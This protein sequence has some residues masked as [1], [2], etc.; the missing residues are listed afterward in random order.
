MKHYTQALQYALSLPFRSW[1]FALIMIVFVLGAFGCSSKTI[2]DDSEVPVG[3]T[4]FSFDQGTYPSDLDL[5]AKYLINPGDVLDVLFQ[6]KR[7]KAEKFPITLYHTVSLRFVNVPELNVTQEVMPTGKIVLPY[8][9]EISVLG[10]TASELTKE[11]KEAYSSVLR[12]PEL[13]VTIPNFNVRIDQIREDLR[14]APR[15]LSK[16]IY[17]RPDGVATFPLIGRQMVA[18]KTIE[19]VNSIIQE[20][21]TDF[22]PG[23]KVDLF[24][25]EKSGSVV[26]LVGEVTNSGTYEI[27]KP[28]TVLQALTLAGG[29]T[30]MANLENVIV[31]RK[32]EKKR[33]AKSLNL[34]DLSQVKQGSAFFYIRP[35]DI[36][37]VPKTRI[38]SL[39]NLMNQISDIA[40]FNGWGFGLGDEVD[41]I[42][43]NDNQNFGD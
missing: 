11:L 19:Q 33:L 35:D 22:M 32:H 4:T 1:P 31:F 43:P 14:T 25:H 7:Q 13:Y 18:S 37:F 17:V 5:F 38:A 40:L 30:P 36:I 10:K 6:I 21:Y 9:G 8:I 27:N 2:P 42:G 29:Y 3:R 39:A 20:R 28:I 34:K 12:E 23:M 41:W 26:Y 24:L 16:L 15:G